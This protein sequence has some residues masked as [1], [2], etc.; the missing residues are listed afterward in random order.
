MSSEEKLRTLHDLLQF[1]LQF[2]D[3]P[4]GGLTGDLAVMGAMNGQCSVVHNGQIIIFHED[5]LVGVF[6]DRA[7]EMRVS[8]V[9]IER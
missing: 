5:H 9:T 6:D 7:E 8:R 2:V 4:D 3:F 1:D